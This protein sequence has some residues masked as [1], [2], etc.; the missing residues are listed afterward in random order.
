MKDTLITIYC[1]MMG[2]IAAGLLYVTVRGLIAYQFE[3]SRNQ[4]LNAQN[5]FIKK[6]LQAAQQR[7]T[8]FHHEHR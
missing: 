8:A 2:I 3:M 7:G 4:R 5:D 1:V 6:Q